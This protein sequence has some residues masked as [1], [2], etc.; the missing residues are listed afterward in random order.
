MAGQGFERYQAACP[1]S[2]GQFPQSIF[3]PWIPE[4]VDVWIYIFLADVAQEATYFNL[5][6]TAR[7]ETMT[8]N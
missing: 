7:N 1:E 8:M 6:F 5:C 3:P 2:C 4:Q